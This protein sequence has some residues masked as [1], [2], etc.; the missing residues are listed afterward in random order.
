MLATQR[1]L[2]ATRMPGELSDALDLEM[3]PA[4]GDGFRQ[5]F[6]QDQDQDQDH[7]DEHEQNVFY[8]TVHQNICEG[9]GKRPLLWLFPTRPEGIDGIHFRKKKNPQASIQH[10]K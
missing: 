4:T 3:G 10:N 2:E 1:R 7:D 9:L 5:Q 8:T 6:D